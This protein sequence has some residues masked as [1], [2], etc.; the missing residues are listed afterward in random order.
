MN[1]K[2]DK[3]TLLRRTPGLA[4]VLLLAV[5]GVWMLQP[6]ARL[7][8]WLV[9]A[10]Y[11]LSFSFSLAGFAA[12]NDTPV[13]IVYLDLPSYQREGQSPAQP[14]DRSIHTRL[15]NRL[16][17]AG[18]KAVVFDIVFSDPGPDP[19][20]DAAFAQSL[21]HH[22]TVILAAEWHRS[23]R[24]T[25]GI[26]QVQTRTVSLPCETLRQAAAG[27]GYAITQVDEDLKA[28]RYFAGFLERDLPSLTWVTARTLGLLL[29]GELSAGQAWIRYYGPPFTI[30]HVSYSAA[31]APHETPD[32]SFAG[33]IVFVGARPV[34][35]GF[36]QRR[37]ELRSPFSTLTQGDLFM[38]GVE[39]HATQMLNLIRGDWLRR[40]PRAFE[41]GILAGTAL[42]LGLALFGV[43][44]ATAAGLA[45]AGEGIALGAAA[46][47]F[48]RHGI[49]FPWM[50]IAAVQIPL[51][52]LGSVLVQS[53]GWYRQRRE[54]LE[55]IRQQAL[56]IDKAQ[57]MILVTDLTGLI[58][59]ANPSALRG[60]SSAANPG[61]NAWAS[62]QANQGATDPCQDA[63]QAL[64]AS[65]GWSGEFCHPG[66]HGDTILVATSWTLLRDE[67]GRPARILSI[68]TDITEKRRLE[69]QFA[70]AQRLETIGTLASGMTHDLNNALAPVLMGLETLQERLPDESLRSMVKL[71]ESN[72]RRGSEMVRQVL[73]FSRGKGDELQLLRLSRLVQEVAVLLRQTL[74]KNVEVS[75]LLAKDIWPVR[76]HPT[77]VQQ[78]LLN[79][80]LNARDAM[81]NG[82]KLTL[83]LDNVEL[84]AAEAATMPGATPGCFVSLMVSDTGTGMPPE[85]LK[86]MFEPFFTTKPVGKGT[87]LGLLSVKH[88]TRQHGGFVHIQSQMGTGTIFEVFLPAVR[89]E[90]PRF[91]TPSAE[92]PRGCGELVLVLDD[93]LAVREFI[94]S[95]LAEHGYQVIAAG[96]CLE[97]LALAQQHG[98]NIRLVI[99]DWRVPGV[100]NTGAAAALRA[101]LPG[102]PFV[103]VSGLLPGE[104]ECGWPLTPPTSFL[105]KPFRLETL[106]HRLKEVS[107]PECSSR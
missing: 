24:R 43:R 69:E 14:W 37:D 46:F 23:S 78:I 87:G 16:K 101:A 45:F 99:A 106:L 98:A 34:I 13:L 5:I 12:E 84:T 1:T 105:L 50:T 102:V 95:G 103:V 32:R 51:A 64:L 47:L 74:P 41:R 9:R 19:K 77:Q 57:D 36:D 66:V 67:L 25:D 35:G 61:R 91:A 59:Y 53:L 58:L 7:G 80:C 89:D 56:L 17:A 8:Q 68:G 21:R 71:M 100:D 94:A 11:D 104:G 96:N 40:F 48:T 39:V 90:K 27:C 63:K 86:K 6:E 22:G 42:V 76:G 18:A 30:P 75:E 10:S 49:W 29:P 2:L 79:L 93:E 52:L 81:P 107:P 20:A 33:K 62:I 85:V 72:A 28:R 38:P 70:K 55:R 88:I 60:Y 82:G 97:A 73:L 44:P 15:V 54:Y 65:G 31:L 3:R 83:A 4:A 92:L 26:E